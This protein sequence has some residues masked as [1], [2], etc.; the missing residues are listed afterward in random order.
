MTER[1]QLKIKLIRG[2]AGWSQKQRRV[3]KGLGLYH[4]NQEVIHHETDT[5]V[6][7]IRKIPHLLSV[8]AV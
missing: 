1:R 6:G 5:I 2:L 8:E 4:L 7:M 3:V